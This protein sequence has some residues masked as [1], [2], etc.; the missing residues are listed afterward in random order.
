MPNFEGKVPSGGS[1]NEVEL[2]T[3]D[4]EVL[5]DNPEALA[6]AKA[7]S[8]HSLSNKEW[9]RAVRKATGRATDEDKMVEIRRILNRLPDDPKETQQEPDP[10]AKE[11]EKT[12]QFA[13]IMASIEERAAQAR[14]RVKKW[15]RGS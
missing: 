15:L 6:E 4:I 14:E 13:S 7:E 3:D 2:S 8:A 9:A 5:P 1:F 10:Q 11:A 12:T